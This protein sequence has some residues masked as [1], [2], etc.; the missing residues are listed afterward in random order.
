MEHNVRFG[1]PECQS[2]MARLDSDLCEA[3][4]RA[5]TGHLDKVS[6]SW[7]EQ[8]AVTVV[9]AAKGYPGNYSK[10]SVI[11]GLENIQGAKVGHART[12]FC[13]LASA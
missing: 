3:L 11:R 13:K 9:L 10:G 1:D 6:L 12:M 8:A 2:L 4:M 7:K 5:S